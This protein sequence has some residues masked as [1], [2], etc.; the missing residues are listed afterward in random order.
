MKKIAISFPIAIAAISL[1]ACGN[2]NEAT[3]VSTPSSA[4]V[5]SSKSPVQTGQW[6][7]ASDVAS[8]IHAATGN[9]PSIINETEGVAMC[10]GDDTLYIISINSEEYPKIAQQHRA[11]AF[12]DDLQ[13]DEVLLWEEGWTIQCRG[14]STVRCNQIHEL[15]PAA[16]WVDLPKGGLFG[17][18]FVSEE[19]TKKIGDGIHLVGKDITPGTYRT[20]GGEWC[21]WERKAGL[22]GTLGDIIANDNSVEKRQ[23][24]VSIEPSD[25]AFESKR[26]GT[27]ELVN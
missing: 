21:Y 5:S 27:W 16:T 25:V 6:K 15:L 24:Y 14:N 23:I 20:D 26:C 3:G 18:D 1:A 13:Q 22:S 10:G 12:T 7:E 8:T 9:C 2:L 4:L 17:E 19:E 11:F